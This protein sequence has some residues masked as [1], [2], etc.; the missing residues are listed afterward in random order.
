VISRLYLVTWALVLFLVAGCSKDE[1]VEPTPAATEV[2]AKLSPAPTPCTRPDGTII[3]CRQRVPATAWL[4]D[5]RSASVTTLFESHEDAVWYGAF[6]EAGQAVIGIY[7]LQEHRMREAVRFA[8]DGSEA[9]REPWADGPL[10]LLTRLLGWTPGSP[11]CR[12][13]DGGAEVG[14]RF[15]AEVSCGQSSPDGRWLVYATGGRDIEGVGHFYDRWL[16]DLAT[17]ARQQLQAGLRQCQ[18]DSFFGPQWSST[19]AYVFFGDCAEDGRVFV[20]DIAAGRT[21]QVASGIPSLRLMPDWS[22]ASDKLLVPGAGGLTVIENLTAGES[23]VLDD[24]PWPAKFDPT[25]RY[26]YSPAFD[27]VPSLRTA[28]PRTAIYDVAEGRVVAGLPGVPPYENTYLAFVPVMRTASGFAAALERAP[29]CDGTAIYS[30]SA[31]VACVRGA[32][33]PTFSPDGSKVALARQSGQTGRVDFPGGGDASLIRYDILIVD[34][35][36]GAERV[37]ARDALAI[38]PY[39]QPSVWNAASTH[40]LVRWPFLFAP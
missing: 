25:G 2:A 32:V 31:L 1:P 27:S 18:G 22:Q 33:G 17:G 16:L 10:S 39:P 13:V 7:D 29:G 3:P 15:H 4:I 21:R 12:N 26:V 19:G 6:D 24:V 14:G 40:I 37:V 20:S 5:V 36:T 23:A 30:N 8:L 38:N 9:G 11:F 34:A 28:E 35:A